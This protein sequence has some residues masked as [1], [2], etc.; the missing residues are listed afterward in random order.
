MHINR[1]RYVQIQEMEA[2]ENSQRWKT[3]VTPNAIK[4]H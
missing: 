3:P 4:R 1:Q 2:G